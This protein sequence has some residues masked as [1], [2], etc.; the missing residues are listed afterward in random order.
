MISRPVQT[1]VNER[2]RIREVRL[3]DEQGEQV[4][5]VPTFE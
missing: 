2:I 1:R 3:I 4:G 5:I